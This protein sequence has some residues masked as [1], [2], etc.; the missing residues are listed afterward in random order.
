MLIGGVLLAAG[1][2]LQLQPEDYDGDREIHVVIQ[3]VVGRGGDW[4]SLVAR[5]LA[6]A[7]SPWRVCRIKVKVAALNRSLTLKRT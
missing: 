3:R 6:S 1:M 7:S 5:E 4:V 2:E